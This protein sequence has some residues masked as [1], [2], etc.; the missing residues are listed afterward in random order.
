MVHTVIKLWLP[1]LHLV[2]LSE[3]GERPSDTHADSLPL[4]SL[5]AGSSP[6]AAFDLGQNQESSWTSLLC[7]LLG[8]EYCDIS[9]RTWT[10]TSWFQAIYAKTHSSTCFRLLLLLCCCDKTLI[11]PTWGGKVWVHFSTLSFHSITEERTRLELKQWRSTTYWFSRHDLL[12]L[13]FN[14]I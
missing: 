12:T 2:T 13:L 5:P 6:K 14:I 3:E 10:K 8:W 9:S 11:K 7:G 1:Q 4:I